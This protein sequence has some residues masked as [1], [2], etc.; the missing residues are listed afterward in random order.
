M[1]QRALTARVPTIELSTPPMPP[2]THT[3]LDMEKELWIVGN[4]IELDV[5]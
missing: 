4:S 3:P 2:S 5:P 1:N